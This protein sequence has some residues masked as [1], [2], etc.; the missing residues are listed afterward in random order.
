M[1][2]L[3]I[4]IVEDEQVISL[5]IA[6]LLTRYGYE[7][8]GT[9][10]YG[11]EFLEALQAKTIHPNLVLMDIRLQGNMDG[12]T[13]AQKM[14]E[15]HLEIPLIF[16]TSNSDKDTILKSK[17]TNP[18]AFLKKPFDP[19][20]LQATL[21]VS[22]HGNEKL[23]K[24]RKSLLK[25]NELNE[26]QI[27]ELMETQQHL[28]A[29]TWR[30]RELKEELQKS[31]TI[32]EE[33]NKKI[34]DSINYAR[35]IQKA[36]I[37][38]L[39][40][41]QKDLPQTEWVYKPKDVVSGDFPYYKKKGNLVYYAVVDCTGHGVPGAMMSLIGHLILNDVLN[42]NEDYTP[43][44][45][46]LK[47][48]Q[49]VVK[50]LKQDDP[51]NKAADGMD[52]GIICYNLE[53]KQL[54]YSGAHR[55]L[56]LVRKGKDEIIQY[57]GGKYPVGGDQYK[58]ANQ[59]PNYD[60]EIQEGDTVYF[61]SDGY[62]DQFGGP[63]NLKI[64]PKRIRKMLIENANKTLTENI[65]ELGKIFDDWKGNSKQMDDVLMIGVKF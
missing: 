60:V 57:K 45:V 5:H 42:S 4:V 61:F 37:P 16:L 12:I 15:E 44:E 40:H 52:V 39:D 22:F 1:D 24:E 50:T 63:E 27:K 6:D 38:N 2:K 11:E 30:E 64:G 29:A 34:M 17:K 19:D 32:I 10:A 14:Q 56:Y 18:I 26:M 47:L 36:I 8:E 48:H 3:K 20:Q 65:A 35:R 49:G 23:R 62:P 31:K 53:T 46:L 9:F 43:A 33:Q 55:P 58:G 41:I 59:Y 28:V 25:T 51:E 54:Q 7:V 21:E 13:V